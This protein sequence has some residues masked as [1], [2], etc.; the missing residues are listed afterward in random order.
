MLPSFWCWITFLTH[1]PRG[2]PHLSATRGHLPCLSLGC[3]HTV[4][5]ARGGSVAQLALACPAQV[6][7]A[8]ATTAHS[9]AQPSSQASAPSP[10]LGPELH[11]PQLQARPWASSFQAVLR[12]AGAVHHCVP[13]WLE[14]LAEEERQGR[15]FFPPAKTPGG[16]FQQH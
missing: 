2:R 9:M 12:K 1:G 14:S 16:F 11:Q 4:G 5:G 10:G 13:S 8:G 6:Q 15:S 3:D 7:R